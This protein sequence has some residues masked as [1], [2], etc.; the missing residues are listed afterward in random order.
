MRKIRSFIDY[1]LAAHT[2][3]T[4]PEGP[5]HHLLRVLRLR[6]GSQVHLFDGS[7]QEYPAEILPAEHRNECRVR[8]G[9]P[10]AAAVESPLNITLYQAIGRGERMD[11][12]IQKATE[13]GVS[14]IVPV[15]SERTEVRLDGERA[16]K[17]RLH[18]QQVVI[19][20]AE[21]SGRVRVPEV[22]AVRPLDAVSAVGD[23][24]V[25]LDP[26]AELGLAE[27]GDPADG[28]CELLVGP[29]GG[30]SETERLLLQHQGF[31]PLR[32]GPRVLRTETAGPVMIA[33][34]QA[35]FGDFR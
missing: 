29:E 16:E 5:A 25:F 6:P 13:L 32:L 31:R 8:L 19:A 23:I 33:L 26:L 9:V 35:R 21:Q 3:M 34:L 15:D 14:R 1:P 24:A 18:W 22:E 17:R 7:G 11:W 2:E 27:L 28:C 10:A 12:S 4:L 30:L 20:A